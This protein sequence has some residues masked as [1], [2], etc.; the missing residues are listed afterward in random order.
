METVDSATGLTD[1]QAYRLICANGA[2]TLLKTADQ[3]AIERRH[4]YNVALG[5]AYARE[6]YLRCISN[7]RACEA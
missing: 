3:M 2:G 6:Q 1:Q 7:P 5:R 4:A